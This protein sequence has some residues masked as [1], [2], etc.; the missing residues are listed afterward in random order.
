M[1][2]TIALILVTLLSFCHSMKPQDELNQRNHDSEIRP[3]ATHN[4]QA[5]IIYLIR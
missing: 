2:I 3:S 1:R 5:G 4:A